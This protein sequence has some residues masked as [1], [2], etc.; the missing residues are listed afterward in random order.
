MKNG[1]LFIVIGLILINCSFFILQDE[2]KKRNS[3]NSNDYEVSEGKEIDNI[4]VKSYN[5][6]HPNKVI[7]N[8][9]KK[10]KC[11]STNEFTF[12]C[13]YDDLSNIEVTNHIEQKTIDELFENFKENTP[14]KDIYEYS[15]KEYDCPSYMKCGKM[16]I[17]QSE[18][19][20][21]EV[22]VIYIDSGVIYEK[23]RAITLVRFKGNL[24]D[25]SGDNSIKK[26]INSITIEEFNEQDM[27]IDDKL[28]M[29]F[30]YSRIPSSQNKIIISLD[31]NKYKYPKN[32]YLMTNNDKIIDC[33]ES[34]KRIHAIYAYVDNKTLASGMSLFDGIIT[35]YG[36]NLLEF[37]D[38]SN[39]KIGNKNIY[40][41]EEGKTNQYIHLINDN[42]IF[43]ITSNEILS[44]IELIDLFSYNI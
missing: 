4:Y 33:V 29:D 34:N 19:N 39:K 43:F 11:Y 15:F 26:L 22:G 17:K 36:I 30:S 12:S 9:D 5:E 35:K 38:Y 6:E 2:L 41:I 1:L 14:Y 13:E 32:N 7:F 21:Y 25:D 40:V 37:N 27:P 42:S 8:F 44:D 20:G 31:S 18:S 10:Y 28:V 16:S 23:D 24:S 3:D